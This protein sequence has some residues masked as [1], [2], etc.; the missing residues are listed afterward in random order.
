MADTVRYA[1]GVRSLAAIGVSIEK[2]FDA[3]VKAEEDHWRPGYEAGIYCEDAALFVDAKMKKYLNKK[4]YSFFIAAAV[5]LL[6]KDA[7]KHARYIPAVEAFIK[8][9]FDADAEHGVEWQVACFGFTKGL[10]TL[11]PGLQKLELRLM[12]DVGR[13][14]YIGSKEETVEEAKRLKLPPEWFELWALLEENDDNDDPSLA[15]H[16]KKLF[17][18]DRPLFN[19]VH[20]AFYWRQDLPRES[21]SPVDDP[22]HPRT[23]KSQFIDSFKLLAICLAHGECQEEFEDLKKNWTKYKKELAELTRTKYDSLLSDTHPEF[24]PYTLLYEYGIEPLDALFAGYFSENAKRFHAALRE[25]FSARQ[26]WA[27]PIG[28]VKAF[29]ALKHGSLED[30]FLAWMDPPEE[31]RAAMPPEVIRETIAAYPDESR[32]FLA[33]A[34]KE[35]KPDGVLRLLELAFPKDSEAG[36]NGLPVTEALVLFDSTS[37]KVLD[38]AQEIFFDHEAEIRPEIE[39]RL[40]K[41][42]KAASLAAQQLVARWNARGTKK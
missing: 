24:I 26:Y 31:R 15:D 30:I 32:A 10:G 13:A 11:S 42:K 3:C 33:K 20:R 12:L 8:D 41:Y 6:E 19:K 23:L 14:G 27:A 17:T 4:M 16:F 40:P 9:T 39:A 1:A 35:C 25:F 18:E 36:S 29:I 28:A 22:T 38:A 2:V 34:V 37:K 21:G 5:A 7:E